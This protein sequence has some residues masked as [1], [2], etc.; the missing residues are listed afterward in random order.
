M[1]IAL[2]QINPT[3]GDFENNTEKMMGFIEKAK[4]RNCDL[5][6][7]SELVISGYPPRDFLEKEDFV[8]ANPNHFHRLVESVR[9]IGVVCGFA[10]KNPKQHGMPLFNSAVLFEDGKVLHQAH[11][12]L[13]PAY[14]VFDETRY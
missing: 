4:G 6:V 1:K 10:D 13:L 8:F 7:F 14:D 3:I 11:K 12:R 2:A 9:G 5:I